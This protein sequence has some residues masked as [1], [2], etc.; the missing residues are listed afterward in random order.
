M[1]REAVE[2]LHRVEQLY[3][4]LARADIEA[5][6]QVLSASATI[7]FA[8]ASPSVPW[9]GGAR[10][11]EQIAAYLRS[12]SEQLAFEKF[13]VLGK[14][15]STEHAAL[16]IHVRY[17]VKKT[18]R[19]VDQVQVHWLTFDANEV[20]SLEHFEDTALVMWAAGDTAA[21]DMAN[22][23]GAPLGSATAHAVET[24]ESS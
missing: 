23:H 14:I 13:E 21:D 8:G 3:G 24:G 16:R 9:H 17:R 22:H 2:R 10:G 19:V 5:L 4:A 15:V 6:T 18:G 11:P 12:L 1:E 7:G 20:T